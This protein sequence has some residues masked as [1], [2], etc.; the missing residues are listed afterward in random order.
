MKINGEVIPEGVV[1]ECDR[2]LVWGAKA[3][4]RW[5]PGFSLREAVDIT[6]TIRARLDRGESAKESCASCKAL[7]SELN[8]VLSML[9]AAC[10]RLNPHH[11]GC[12]SCGDTE[13]ARKLIAEHK[14]G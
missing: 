14:G 4:R 13:E 11:E 8:N 2:G 1:E 6:K 12:T 9:C 7:A 5:L 10:V 3:V